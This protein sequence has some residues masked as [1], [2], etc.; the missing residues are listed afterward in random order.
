MTGL[1]N[2]N[3]DLQRLLCNNTEL[4][5]FLNNVKYSLGCLTFVCIQ[6]YI[7]C[8]LILIQ[9]EFTNGISFLNHISSVIKV[10][11]IY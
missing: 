9:D 6:I 5:F 8:K 2:E 11:Y 3:L 1:E 7:I 4:C 10:M